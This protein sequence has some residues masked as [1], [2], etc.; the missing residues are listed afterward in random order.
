MTTIIIGAGP[1]GMSIAAHFQAAGV[2]FRIFGKPMHSWHHHMPVGTLLKSE[3]LSCNIYDPANRFT[4]ERFCT[5]RHLHCA[6]PGQPVPLAVM[7]AYGEAFQRQLVPRL[8]ERDI[9]AVAR[10]RRGFLLRLDD[11][12]MIDAQR[13]IVATGLAGFRRMPLTLSLLPPE[14]AS[15]SSEHHSLD[16]FAGRDVVVLGGGPSAIDLAVLLRRSGAAVRLVA[17]RP[18][19][20][21]DAPPEAAALP[22][23]HGSLSGFGGLAHSTFSDAPRLFHALPETAR[24][25][26]LERMKDRAAGWFNAEPALGIPMRLGYHLQHADWRSGRA[27]LHF[28]DAAGD[29]QLVSAEHVI[30]ATGYEAD[31]RRLGFL[32][33][34]IRRR[35]VRC[36]E[37]PALSANFQSSIPGLYFVGLAAAN[38][39]GPVM[40]SMAGARF[41]ARHLTRHLRRADRPWPLPRPSFGRM[42]PA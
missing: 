25:W 29:R 9:V 42:R 6:I 27:R 28:V 8:D 37:A 4:F 22:R 3:G 10:D 15:H 21:F 5:D 14:F 33:E 35:L 41:T 38:S 17:R 7:A 31:L 26:L 24:L 13:V 39:F 1:Y 16:H 30:A 40:Q 18:T 12:E 36:G 20:A 11:G 32:G 19:L 2:D 23:R 34:D